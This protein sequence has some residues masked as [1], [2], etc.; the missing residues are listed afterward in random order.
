[1]EMALGIRHMFCLNS[2]IASAALIS[3]AHRFKN[4][5]LDSIIGDLA[6]MILDECIY[7]KFVREKLNTLEG[8]VQKP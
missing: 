1:M 5:V 6:S 8:M 2:V 7:G 3:L 4:D